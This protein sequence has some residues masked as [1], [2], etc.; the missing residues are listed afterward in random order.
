M[1][2]AD[3]HNPSPVH[4]DEKRC[5]AASTSQWFDERSAATHPLSANNALE[6]YVCGKEA[7]AKIAQDI[8]AARHSID[9]VCWGFDPGMELVREGKDKHWPRGQPFGSLLHAAA[10]RGVK[11]RLLVWYRKFASEKQNNMPGFTGDQREGYFVLTPTTTRDDY[12]AQGRTAPIPVLGGSDGRTPEQLR[13][14]YCIEWWRDV[15]SDPKPGTTGTRIEVRMRAGSSTEQVQRST[16]LDAGAGGLAPEDPASVDGLASEKVLLEKFATHHQK[17]ILIDYAFD[18]GA[19]AVGYVMGLN[20]VTDYW[21]STEHLFDDPRRETDWARKSATAEALPR[22]QAISRDPY[23]DYASRI[24]GPALQQVHKNFIDAWKRDGG[25]VGPDDSGSEPPKLKHFASPGSTIQVVRTQPQ[26]GS[27]KTIKNVYWQA[28]SCARNYIYIENQYF[29]YEAWAR[30]LKGLRAA[31]VKGQQK[32][33]VKACDARMLHLIAVIPWPEDD[34]LVPRTY[35]TVKSLGEA[36]SMPNQ[37]LSMQSKD[38]A[39][40]RW[41]KLPEDQRLDPRNMPA[42]DPVHDTAKR[43]QAPAKNHQTDF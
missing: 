5:I 3:T 8:E 17:T 4:I 13:N 11:V 39:W 40:E 7:F 41:A 23:Q 19:K 30:H 31:F 1:S 2:E 10:G 15:L 27:D 20:S 26:E 14:D 38:E 12:L 21:D 16:A 33:G 35:D 9:L 24:Q 6:V 43:V 34:G 22:A 29:Y 25:K 18:G 28:T 42:W 32:A 37:H 36:D